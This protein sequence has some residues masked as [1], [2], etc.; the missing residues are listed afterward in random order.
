MFS[1]IVG[2]W[3]NHFTVA[4]S[5][6]MYLVSYVFRDSGDWTNHFTVAQSQTLYLVSYVFRDSW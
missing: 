5:E 2:D 4:Q 3:K 1:G 6:M